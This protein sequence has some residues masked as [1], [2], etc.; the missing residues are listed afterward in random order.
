MEDK[1]FTVKQ[2]NLAFLARVLV[3]NKYSWDCIKSTIRNVFRECDGDIMKVAQVV[4]GNKRLKVIYKDYLLIQ[5]AS[6]HTKY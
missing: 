1:D 5:L 4:K 6:E 2:D 3:S